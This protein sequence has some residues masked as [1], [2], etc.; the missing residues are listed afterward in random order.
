MTLL[1]VS[2]GTFGQQDAAFIFQNLRRQLVE[3]VPSGRSTVLIVFFDCL[4][5]FGRR[6]PQVSETNVVHQLT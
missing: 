4:I 3:F 5:S 2:V 6:F 1:T